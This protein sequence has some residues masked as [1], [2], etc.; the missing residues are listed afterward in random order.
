MTEPP[1][2]DNPLLT[3]PQV[4]ASP[5]V[6]GA[7]ARSMADMAEL[8]ARCIVDLR[9]GCWPAGCVVNGELAAGWGW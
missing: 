6:A 1:A 9:Q 4:V 5:H 8:A 7:D 3:L 2:P